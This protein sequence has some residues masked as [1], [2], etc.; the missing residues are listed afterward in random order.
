MTNTFTFLLIT[1]DGDSH[2]RRAAART[3]S[4]LADALRAALGGWLEHISVADPHLSVWCDDEGRLTGRP[5]N[6]V[7]T[8]LV[9]EL[10]RRLP[11][12]LVG[13]V[14]ITGRRGPDTV[15]LT[16]AQLTALHA[17]VAHFR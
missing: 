6:P 8:W 5:L 7:A 3:D 16:D 12:L 9:A 17:M 10:D 11:E 15:S 1:E 4:D 2:V 13:P 14:A